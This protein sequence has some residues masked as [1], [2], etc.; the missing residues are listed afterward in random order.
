MPTIDYK[1]AN[2]NT[3]KKLSKTLNETGLL[4]E[5]IDMRMGVN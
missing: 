1:K 5:N 3:L 2:M 4:P